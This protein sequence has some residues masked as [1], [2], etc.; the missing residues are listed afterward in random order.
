MTNCPKLHRTKD[1]C[2]IARIADDIPETAK[3]G[4]REGALKALCEIMHRKLEEQHRKMYP[5]VPTGPCECQ[6]W[7]MPTGCPG[8]GIYCMGG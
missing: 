6:G 4:S 5:F 1:G 7:G 2:W 3:Y 8:C